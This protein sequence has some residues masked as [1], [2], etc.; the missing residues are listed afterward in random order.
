[1]QIAAT[2]V[3]VLQQGAPVPERAAA[4]D[5]LSS[6]LLLTLNDQMQG[7]P[8]AAAQL[9]DKTLS[10]K[11]LSSSSLSSLLLPPTATT[12]PSPDDSPMSDTERSSPASE[13]ELNSP[14][15]SEDSLVANSGPDLMSSVEDQER[16]LALRI[17]REGSCFSCVPTP[18]FSLRI[19]P[20]TPSQ[21]ELTALEKQLRSV[22]GRFNALS[23]KE[24]AL[25][26]FLTTLDISGCDDVD[27]EQVAL[28]LQ[29][30][31]LVT[32]LNCSYSHITAEV[33]EQLL[34]QHPSTQLKKLDLSSCRYLADDH[35]LVLIA[36]YCGGLTELILRGSRVTSPTIQEILPRL[37]QL[38]TL[39][40]GGSRDLCGGPLGNA[41]LTLFVAEKSGPATMKLL[42]IGN[43]EVPSRMLARLPKTIDI[44]QR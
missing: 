7:V 37:P 35:L 20:P 6:L 18:D 40:L 9:G 23:D 8:A 39:R 11:Q 36:N 26:P 17:A 3:T 2:A 38:E 1:M 28:T 21:Q 5:P 15:P 33:L 12:S 41:L 16:L 32:E 31:P 27:A 44:V 24:K 42:D 43:V 29:N 13:S 30:M 34:Q 19:V 22:G 10:V 4:Q 14:S 25:L